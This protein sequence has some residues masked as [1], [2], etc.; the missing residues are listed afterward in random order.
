VLYNRAKAVSS[1]KQPFL[2]C[3]FVWW[4]CQFLW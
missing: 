3:C 4:S 1:R 2:F